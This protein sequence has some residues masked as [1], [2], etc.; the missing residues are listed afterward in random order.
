MIIDPKE[1]TIAYRCPNCGAG[2]VSV[3]GVFSLSGDMIRL[4]CSCG[5]SEMTMTYTKDRKLRLTIPCII[6]PNPHN[7]TVSSALFFNG[8]M[9]HLG[10][11]YTGLDIAFI[12]RKEDVLDALKESGEMLEGMLEEAGVDSLDMLKN[13]SGKGTAFDDP[14]IEEILRFVIADL[15]DAGDIHCCCGEGETPE[16]TFEFVPPDFENARVFCR[17][18]GASKTLPMTSLTNANEFLA[19]DKL[20]LEKED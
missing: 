19:C 2:V 5:K 1:T 9:F 13:E 11:P 12:G 3:V 17:T 7:Y 8:E 6:C 4:K 16:Y 18:C 10:C 15:S 20:V 14:A